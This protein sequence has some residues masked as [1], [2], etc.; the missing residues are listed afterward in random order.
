MTL[1]NRFRG[2]YCSHRPVTV[3]TTV[4]RKIDKIDS[5]RLENQ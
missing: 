5:H 2:V 3:R 1:P 4:V